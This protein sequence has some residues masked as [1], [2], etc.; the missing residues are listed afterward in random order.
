VTLPHVFDTT[1][2]VALF[3]AHGP[4]FELWQQADRGEI[5]LIFP[6][7]AVAE[8]SE[9][10]DADFNAWEALTYPEHVAIAPLDSSSAPTLD[11]GPIPLSARHALCE[12]RSVNGVLV[13][14]YGDQYWRQD[15]AVL[16][17]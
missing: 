3:R 15:V 17:V 8:T 9:I 7:V 2:L 10:I 11:R 16:V 1:T 14:R 4:A 5:G 6:A 13:T 12:T